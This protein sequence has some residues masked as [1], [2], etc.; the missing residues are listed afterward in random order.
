MK[1][2]EGVGFM[3]KKWRGPPL[4][5]DNGDLLDRSDFAAGGLLEGL[6]VVANTGI[7]SEQQILDGEGVVHDHNESPRSFVETVK[8]GERTVHRPGYLVLRCSLGTSAF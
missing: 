3:F 2:N 8:S 5:W 6:L 1:T 7:R 4:L